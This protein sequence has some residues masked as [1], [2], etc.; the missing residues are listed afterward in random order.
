MQKL[1]FISSLLKRTA[2]IVLLFSSIIIKAQIQL[3]LPTFTGTPGNEVIVDFTVNDLTSYRVQGYQFKIS[4]DPAVIRFFR[5]RKQSS[6][7]YIKRCF[8]SNFIRY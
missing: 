1:I 7:N 5:P 6:R 2:I 4:F 8:N 3:T